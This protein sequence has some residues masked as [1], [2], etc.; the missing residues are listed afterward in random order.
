MDELKRIF[1]IEDDAVIAE[2]MQKYLEGWG[3]DIRCAAD[4]R[5]VTAEF[6]SFDPAIV[7]LDITLP[8]FDGY[9]WC[10]EIRKISEVPVIFISSVSDKMNIVMAVNM[11]GDDFIAKPFDLAVMTAKIRALLRRSYGYGAA[12]T[13]ER[14]E[15]RGAALDL[16]DTNLYIGDDRIELTKNEFRIL[17]VLME[18]QGKV[19]SRDALM[20]KLWDT[21]SFVDENTLNVNV[22]RLR[23]KLVSGGLDDYIQTKKGIGYIVE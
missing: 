10:G 19:V 23:K 15:Y 20:M 18:N 14:L 9:H 12:D 1:I 16:G 7:L 21:D 3:Y 5:N 8:F 6:E 4:F 2:E 17:R 13:R 11:G 22:A